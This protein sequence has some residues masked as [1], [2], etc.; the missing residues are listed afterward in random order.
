MAGTGHTFTQS[1]DFSRLVIQFLLSHSCGVPEG[2]DCNENGVPDECDIAA[3]ASLDCNENGVPDECDCSADLDG[4]GTVNATDLAQLLG[5]WGPN[6]GNPADLNGDDVVD[7]A[8]LAQ[9]LGAWGPC[10]CA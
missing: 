5:A 4:D 1:D 6:P 9:L 10:K 3:G 2:E 7:A 8:D